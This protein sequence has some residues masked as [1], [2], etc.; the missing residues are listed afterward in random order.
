MRVPQ[1][2][3]INAHQ[4][5]PAHQLF[6][7]QTHGSHISYISSLFGLVLVFFFACENFYK[8]R[9]VFTVNELVQ[10]VIT[11]KNQEYTRAK[12][13]VASTAYVALIEEEKHLH[14][15]KR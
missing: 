4:T 13:G 5:T 3:A 15:G 8:D 1:S 7:L 11:S 14:Q 9:F 6:Y 10:Q 2:K 12:Q